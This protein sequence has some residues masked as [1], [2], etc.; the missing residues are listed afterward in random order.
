MSIKVFFNKVDQKLSIYRTNISEWWGKMTN[1]LYYKIRFGGRFISVN[2][3]VDQRCGRLKLRN[4]GDELNV[5][6]VEAL[7]G[8][9][10][11]ST[12]SIFTSNK[13][14]YMVIGSVIDSDMINANSIIWGAGTMWGDSRELKAKPLKVCATR[15]KLTQKYLA[16][17]G[18]ESPDVYGDPA[19]LMPLVYNPSVEKKY[20]LG[21]IPHVF[22]LHDPIVER[23]ATLDKDVHIVPLEN[24]KDWHHVIEEIKSCEFII[25]SSLHGLILSDA[26]QVP[27]AW[28][29]FSDR[30]H[31]GDYKYLDYFSGVNRQISK[32]FV[33]NEHTTISEIYGLA[34]SYEPIVFDSKK[35]LDACP[36]PIK[37][38]Q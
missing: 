10:V 13:P 32:A 36:F 15:G 20:K 6:L 4:L 37:L 1:T 33:V 14:N 34:N 31:G 17:Q 21:V 23:L 12:Y 9:P 19:L 2:C 25:S 8:R 35:L 22:D 26:Y 24:Y 38:K 30:I 5:F 7:A 18:V 28:V 3:W 11:V 27:N 29:K 16:S